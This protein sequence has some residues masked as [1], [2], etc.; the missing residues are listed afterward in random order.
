MDIVLAF[1][2]NTRIHRA[3]GGPWRRGEGRRVC[4]STVRD[5]GMRNGVGRRGG[6][7]QSDRS[8]RIKAKA[9]RLRAVEGRGKKKC[10]K[11][12]E[13]LY[14]R[15]D[16]SARRGDQEEHLT[17]H[18]HTGTLVHQLCA[19]QLYCL[20]DPFLALGWRVWEWGLELPRLRASPPRTSFP[21]GQMAPLP[22]CAWRTVELE[23][24]FPSPPCTPSSQL[25]GPLSLVS[26]HL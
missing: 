17:Q 23:Q 6:V 8:A 20:P 12:P 13:I 22:G 7:R 14:C 2:V 21:H 1:R 18:W 26:D 16:G 24:T 11:H 25:P 19:R 5:E 4:R 15:S 10:Q 3:Q 9:S